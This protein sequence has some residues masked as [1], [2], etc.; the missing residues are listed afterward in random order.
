MTSS[1]ERE[2]AEIERSMLP[3]RE[4]TGGVLRPPQK[5][6]L[7]GSLLSSVLEQILGRKGVRPGFQLTKSHPTVPW[8]TTGNCSRNST[9]EMTVAFTN[10][11]TSSEER[12][13]A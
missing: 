8:I 7:E 1:E 4:A 5:G 9:R 12:P 10:A 13:S 6:G 11:L 2:S 3:H